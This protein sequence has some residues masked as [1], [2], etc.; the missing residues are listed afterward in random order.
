LLGDIRYTIYRNILWFTGELQRLHQHLMMRVA[1]GLTTDYPWA[2]KN[3]IEYHPDFYDGETG[4]SFWTSWNFRFLPIISCSGVT[5][6]RRRLRID[7]SG[8][9]GSTGPTAILIIFVSAAHYSGN[10]GATK[11]WHRFRRISKDDFPLLR[12]H[13][14]APPT[15]L[16][17]EAFSSSLIPHPVLELARFLLTIIL[18]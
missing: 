3:L 8:R 6:Y 2:L 15:A 10:L 9:N 18:A 1:S 7:P 13:C 17:I 12:P 16:G 5:P 11:L 14:T 4:A